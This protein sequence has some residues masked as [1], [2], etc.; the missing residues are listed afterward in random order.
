QWAAHYERDGVFYRGALPDGVDKVAVMPWVHPQRDRAIS[1]DCYAHTEYRWTAPQS[2]FADA[3]PSGALDMLWQAELVT[4]CAR[5]RVP[6]HRRATMEHMRRALR[7]H[8]TGAELTKGICAALRER[9]CIEA[10]PAIPFQKE[11]SNAA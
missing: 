5:H 3:L 4:M 9:I 1:T 7:W 11:T 8:L 6:A 10:D 2:P